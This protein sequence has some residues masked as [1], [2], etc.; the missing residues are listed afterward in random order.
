MI[1]YASMICI[2]H[3]VSASCATTAFAVACG[4]LKLHELEV[5]L[6]VASESSCKVGHIGA[7]HACV[8]VR[9]GRWKGCRCRGMLKN[10]SPGRATTC[11]YSQAVVEH[12]MDSINSVWLPQSKG[13]KERERERQ[14]NRKSRKRGVRKGSQR[15]NSY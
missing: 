9:G 6:N 8:C 2:L 3:R 4:A 7:T 13:K 14:E 11:S 15:Y 10:V 12:V 5:D 1:I